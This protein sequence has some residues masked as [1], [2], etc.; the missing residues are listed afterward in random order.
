MPRIAIRI[1]KI[2]PK[3]LADVGVVVSEEPVKSKV[4]LLTNGKVLYTDI[5]YADATNI[6]TS[7][8][9]AQKQ[10]NIVQSIRMTMPFVPEVAEAFDKYNIKIY[11]N[12]KK[13][14]AYSLING[15]KNTNLQNKRLEFEIRKVEVK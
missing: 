13:N 7:Q 8:N 11:L 1:F 10:N 5:F 15:S 3:Y 12:G 9:I 14:Q 2:V 4:G 6:N